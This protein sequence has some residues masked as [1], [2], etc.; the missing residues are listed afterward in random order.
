MIDMLAGTIIVWLS[1]F[2]YYSNP[3]GNSLRVGSAKTKE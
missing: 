3:Q 2:Y 1:K